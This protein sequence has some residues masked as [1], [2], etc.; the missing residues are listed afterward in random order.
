M[1]LSQPTTW[2]NTTRAARALDIHPVT[3]RRKRNDGYLIE[4]VH[5]IKMGDAKNSQYIWNVE[6]I[7]AVFTLWKA[8]SNHLGGDE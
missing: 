5:F 1:N 4:G 2:L 3:L 6:K 8:P 7:L